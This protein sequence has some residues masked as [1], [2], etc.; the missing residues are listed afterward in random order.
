MLRAVSPA[1]LAARSTFVLVMLD[2][3]AG[4]EALLDGPSGLQAGVHS[5]TTLIICTATAPVPLRA[6]SAR[7]FDATA[8][9]VRMVEAPLTGGPAELSG[10]QMSIMVGADRPTYDA[11][12]PVLALLGRPV[13]IGQLGLG[14]G[15]R[16]SD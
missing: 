12:E 10:G 4:F 7:L 11:V 3:P 5:P 6:L 15:V 8:G 9:L 1:D 14:S 13:L 2:E 16:I